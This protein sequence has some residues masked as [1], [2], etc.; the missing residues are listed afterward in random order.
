MG[1]IAE[2]VL[3]DC[4]D[5]VKGRANKSRLRKPTK[6]HTELQCICSRKGPAM[7]LHWEIED[8]YAGKSRPQSTTVDEEDYEGMTLEQIKIDLE[9]AINED[10]ASRISWWSQN[11][12]E[13][14]EEIFDAVGE[15]TDAT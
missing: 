9:N 7:E 8:G 12:N 13:V 10:M 14:A 3:A 2:P 15:K 6:A 1:G 4:D 11:L 5:A